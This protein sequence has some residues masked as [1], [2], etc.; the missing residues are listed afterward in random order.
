M[1]GTTAAPSRAAGQLSRADLRDIVLAGLPLAE[2]LGGGQ[3]PGAEP[4]DHPASIVLDRWR[5]L[6]AESDETTFGKRLAWDGWDI[7]SVRA[8]LQTEPLGPDDPL[9]PWA[10][11][12]DAVLR[13][14][15][16]SSSSPNGSQPVDRSFAADWPIPFEHVLLPFVIFARDQLGERIGPSSA[17]VSAGAMATLEHRLLQRLTWVCASPLLVEFGARRAQRRSSLDRLFGR[18]QGEPDTTQYREF[19]DHMLTA[20]WADLLRSYPVL[21]RLAATV[22]DLWVDTTAELVVRL[23]ADREEIEATFHPGRDLGAVA[24]IG[25]AVSDA[26]N[27]GRSVLAITFESGLKV[28]YKPKALELE[29]AYFALLG[30]LEERGAPLP[31][32]RLRVVCRPGYGWTEFAETMPCADA[33]AAR[34]YYQRAG[35][36]LCLLYALAGD[37]CHYDNIVAS[38]EHP[39]LVDME[40]FMHPQPQPYEDD[41]A[42]ENL[43]ARTTATETMRASVLSTGLLPRWMISKEGRSHD[44]SGLGGVEDQESFDKMPRWV[45]VNTDAMTLR[46]EYMTL[47]PT[48]NVVVLDGKR[49]SPNDYV[50]EI[51]DGFAGLYRL[52]VAQRDAMLAPDGPL[53]EFADQPV[54]FMLR[55]TRAYAL[56]LE[57]ALQRQHL[58]DGAVFSVELDVLSRALLSTEQPNLFWPLRRAEQEAM[59]RLDVPFF[60][61]RADSADLQLPTGVTVRGAFTGP[62]FGVVV[63]RLRGLDDDDL[64]RQLAYTR[65]ALF[66]RTATSRDDAFREREQGAPLDAVVP[67]GRDELIAA[68]VR[69]G[70]E[71]DE[72][73]IRSPDGGTSWIGIAY[74]PQAD[75]FQLEPTGYDLYSGNPGIALFL[76]ALAKIT[77]DP[78]TRARADS[79][80]RQVRRAVQAHPERLARGLGIGGVAGTG[81]L[82]YTLVRCG[83]LLDDPTLVS[84]AERVATLITHESIAADQG[85]DVVGGA[86]GALLGLLSLHAITDDPAVLEQAVRCG[87]RLIEQQQVDGSRAGAWWTL[88]QLGI[89]G[90]SHGAA[91]MAYALVRLFEA[92]GDEQ[93]RAVAGAAIAYERR[94]FSAAEQNWPDFRAE[95]SV[96]GRPTFMTAWCHGATGVGLARLGGR[97][98][99]DSAEVRDDIEV[100]LRATVRFGAQGVDHVCCGTMGRADLLLEAGRRLD[101]PELVRTAGQLAAS[102]VADA[103]RRGEYRVVGKLPR[104]AFAPTFFQGT[105]GIGYELLRL[106]EPD[107]LPSVLMLA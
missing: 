71:L 32:K 79:A 77:G 57:R 74:V 11:T 62:S 29:R 56:V 5:A 103:D 83:Q 52:L 42:E 38:G 106:A 64:R 40:T 107:E 43:G 51:V 63:D 78:T 70:D 80:L 1:V 21:G 8:A 37:D 60:G 101:R 76:A 41:A 14:A 73:A 69:I 104:G 3:S 17:E 15:A 39:L 65:S 105:A 67:L 46:Q 49:L 25:Q 13:I 95:A 58:R 22:T 66:S 97:S 28:V 6:V 89:T 2:R 98:A 12:I 48:Q 91:G 35:M 33:A 26:H 96:D 68:A 7:E 45:A 59:E 19:T 54:R 87:R 44:A 20:G 23:R 85:S 75:R 50:E 4:A 31:F 93:F 9:P 102:V 30:W 18:L 34:R 92:T 90:L 10:D 36:L 94:V 53:A 16:T 88:G 99:L 100:A 86:A 27:F 61:A 24:A 55:D 81:S 84:D 72:R 82:V 47:R